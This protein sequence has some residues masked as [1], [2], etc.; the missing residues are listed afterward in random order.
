MVG[1]VDRVYFLKCIQ[2]NDSFEY[3]N[4][5]E[6]G[7]GHEIIE[8]ASL[9]NL[10]RHSSLSIAYVLFE[11]RSIGLKPKPCKVPWA[12]MRLF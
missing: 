7:F 11:D 6:A 1:R 8:L 3:S 10:Q 9:F 4:R 5:T 12:Q 2:T